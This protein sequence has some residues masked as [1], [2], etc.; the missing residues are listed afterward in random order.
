[1]LTKVEAWP[2]VALSGLINPHP[3]QARILISYIT[4]WISGPI[5]IF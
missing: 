2:G 4:G 3:H 5:Y 1:M